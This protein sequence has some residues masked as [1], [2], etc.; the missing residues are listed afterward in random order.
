MHIA[1]HS[2]KKYSGSLLALFF[3]NEVISSAF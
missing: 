1:E 3:G 2:E